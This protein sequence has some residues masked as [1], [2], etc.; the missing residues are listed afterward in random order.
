MEAFSALAKHFPD[1]IMGANESVDYGG[2]TPDYR[3]GDAF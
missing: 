2:P 3:S 1:Q